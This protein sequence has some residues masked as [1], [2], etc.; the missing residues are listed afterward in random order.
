MSATT[1]MEAS[2]SMKS[3]TAVES[4]SKARL[5]ARRKASDISAMIKTA[6]GAGVSSQLSVRM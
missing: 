1:A 6:H 3:T 4:A 5:A 2:A